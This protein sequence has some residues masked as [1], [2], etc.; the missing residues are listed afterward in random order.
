MT[1]NT[2]FWARTVLLVV[3][4]LLGL[5]GLYWVLFFLWRSAAEPA[6]QAIWNSRIYIW[7]AV[8]FA[9]FVVWCVLV[10]WILK[11]RKKLLAQ[12]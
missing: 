12:E 11:D 1:R 2:V 10:A 7:A 5:Y 3:T 9:A 8:S 6:Q 4:T